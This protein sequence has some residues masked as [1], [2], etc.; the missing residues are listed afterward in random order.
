MGVGRPTL[1]RRPHGRRMGEEIG[2]LMAIYEGSADA[3][4]DR[5]GHPIGKA[6]EFYG[7]AARSKRVVG[8]W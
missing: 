7:R 6:V 3:T 1:G 4:A 8:A 5:S 2:K